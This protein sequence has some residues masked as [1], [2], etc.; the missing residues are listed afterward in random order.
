MTYIAYDQNGDYANLIE[1]DP[2]NVAEYERLT[3]LRLE[4]PPQPEPGAAPVIS[5][6]EAALNELGVITRE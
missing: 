2:E 3:G 5:D 6:F 4:L 1:I